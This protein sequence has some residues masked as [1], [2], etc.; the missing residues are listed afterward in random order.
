M[1]GWT[2]GRKLHLFLHLDVSLD[3]D[4]LEMLPL[5]TLYEIASKSQPY[6]H[7]LYQVLWAY[8]SS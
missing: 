1:D 3:I 5:I 8:F 2:D 6:L 4:S 7:Q